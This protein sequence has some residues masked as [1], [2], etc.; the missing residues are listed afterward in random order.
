MKNIILKSI[1]MTNIENDIAN[2]INYI[3]RKVTNHLN[4]GE[5]SALIFLVDLRGSSS[6]LYK[7]IFN[8]KA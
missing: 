7:I 1:A 5:K 6:N 2:Q 3:E 8:R 4:E